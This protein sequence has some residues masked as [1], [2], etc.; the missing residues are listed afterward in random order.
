MSGSIGVMYW[1][2][3]YLSL[4]F[5][6]ALLAATHSWFPCCCCGGDDVALCEWCSLDSDTVTITITGLTNDGCPNCSSVNGTYVIYREPDVVCAWS[7]TYYTPCGQL[8]I[9]SI[10][11]PNVPVMNNHGWALELDM[12]AV[13][14]HDEVHYRFDSGSDVPFDCTAEQILLHFYTTTSNGCIGW[15]APGAVTIN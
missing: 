15:D 3:Y 9:R 2:Y 14:I 10:A 12:Q 11:S 8:F 13:G 4:L 1:D 7:E 6:T 5:F